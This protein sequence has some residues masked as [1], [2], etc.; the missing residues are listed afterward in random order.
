[1]NGEIPNMDNMIPF[2]QLLKKVGSRKGVWSDLLLI[3]LAKYQ[4][5]RKGQE[6]T[7]A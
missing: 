5:T 2:L 1:M 7:T 3:L 6:E 4:N